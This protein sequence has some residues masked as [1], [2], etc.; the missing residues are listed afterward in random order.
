M[1]EVKE[2]ITDITG[3]NDLERLLNEVKDNA[4]GESVEIKSSL[5]ENEEKSDM[6]LNTCTEKEKLP[7]NDSEPPSDNTE[8]PTDNTEPPLN[9]IEPSLNDIQPPLNDIEPPLDD[10]EPPLDD[11]VLPLDDTEPPL[12]NTERLSDT[13]INVESK[14]EPDPDKNFSETA[15]DV[16]KI[17]EPVAKDSEEKSENDLEPKNVDQPVINE[18]DP[19]KYKIIRHYLVKWRA[20]TYEESTWELEDDVD[21]DKIE[22]FLRFKEPPPK[23]KW[24]VSNSVLFYFLSCCTLRSK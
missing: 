1:N 9:D 5:V 23:E 10:T 18:E 17:E 22:Q 20:L 6:N 19:S 16:V 15:S 4:D 3:E 12:D 8:S 14:S 13:V 11:T 7:T 2:P 24:K 21:R